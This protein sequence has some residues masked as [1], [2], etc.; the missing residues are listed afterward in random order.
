ME[1]YKKIEFKEEDVKILDC[2][3]AVSS[4]ISA[5]DLY[6]KKEIGEV[7]ERLQKMSTSFELWLVSK[8]DAEI[9]QFYELDTTQ[10]FLKQV[11]RFLDEYKI[12]FNGMNIDKG[13][14]LVEDSLYTE[15]REWLY[16]FV[17]RYE[18]AL[19]G[20]NVKLEDILQE[21][22]QTYRAGEKKAPEP[23]QVDQEAQQQQPEP[24]QV[25]QEQKEELP[26]LNGTAEELKI[27]GRAVEKGYMR[28]EGNG[29]KWNLTKSLLAYMC[30]RLYCRDLVTEDDSDYRET[31]SKNRRQLPANGLKKMFGVDVA[32]NRNQLKAPP[33]GYAKIDDL[34]TLKR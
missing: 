22:K 26:T 28:I 21:M 31:L 24:Q 4:L 11:A 32:N 20:L 10:N 1:Y 5:M 30:G 25:S 33:R 15:T 19:Y 14:Y 27:F 17:Q 9:L 29:Y 13:H 6:D 3:K 34:W 8:T 16:R 2:F 7:V 12:Q 18:P 23:Q